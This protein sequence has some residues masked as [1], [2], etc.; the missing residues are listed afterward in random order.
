MG[1]LAGLPSPLPRL[2]ACRNLFRLLKGSAIVGNVFTLD[3][4]RE[5]AQKKFAP[6]VLTLPD[7]TDV[8]LSNLLKLPKKN[9][10][11]VIEKLR[12]L[13]G[14]GGVDEIVEL[15]TD[16]LLLIA[17]GGG[18]KLVKE[19]GGD[20]TVIMQVLEVWMESTQPGEAKSSPA[21]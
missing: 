11:T 2:L 21:S 20:V 13:E 3:S 1:F 4:L 8:T 17:D 6:V 18:P 7:G 5:E 14:D 12:K 10:E 15:S 16:I 9:R 19:L